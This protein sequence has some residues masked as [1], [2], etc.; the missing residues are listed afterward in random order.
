MKPVE[1]QLRILLRGVADLVSEEALREKLALGR[2][3]RVKLGIDPTASDIHIGFAVV[4][5]KLRQFQEL[6]HQA[7]LI[8]GDATAQVGDP[9]GKNTTRPMLSEAEVRANAESYIEQ[10]GRIV[11][12]ERLEVRYNGEWFS[13]MRFRDTI[14][15]ASRIT[16]AR[17]LE[18][19]DFTKRMEQRL[20]IGLHELFYPMMQAYDSV[21]VRADVELGGT[22]QRFNLLLGRHLQPQFEQPPQVCLMTPLLVGLDGVRKMSKS[23]GNTIG[24]AEAPEQQY[25]KTMSIPDALMRDWFIHATELDLDV[26]ERLL[27]GHPNVAKQR[28]AREIVTLY[29]GPEAAQA[30][31]AHFRK[32]VIEKQ[33]PDEV[34]TFRIE[35]ALYEGEVVPLA[36]LL[37]AAFSISRGEA[38]RLI[39]QGGVRIDGE[40]V[41]DPHHR[42]TP[43]DGQV[44]RAGKRRWVRLSLD[45]A[46]A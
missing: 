3:L 8:V 43:R 31:A 38:R 37:A 29:H 7:V 11:D 35:A 6:G 30:A 2:P 18:R 41:R 46:P 24:I 36:A 28:L 10:I 33:R 44:I 5:R 19:A 14:A 25:G 39:E 9:S 15:L 34:P 26:I 27:Q 16:V 23:Y 21:M 17:V 1:E 4:L 13:P 32:T 20:P 45:G 42:W 22:D 40:V 12:L